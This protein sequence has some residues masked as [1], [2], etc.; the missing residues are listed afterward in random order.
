[1]GFSLRRSALALLPLAFPIVALACGDTADPPPDE[2]SGTADAA[3]TDGSTPEAD[4]G[5]SD[6]ATKPDTSAPSDGGGSV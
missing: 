3:T 6:G 2:D 4:G 5:S 1:M